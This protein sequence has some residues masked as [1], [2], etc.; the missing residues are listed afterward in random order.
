MAD[1][2][3]DHGGRAER[4]LE[5]LRGDRSAPVARVLPDASGRSA[6]GKRI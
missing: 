4:V 3:A 2:L 5:I 6:P 1:R